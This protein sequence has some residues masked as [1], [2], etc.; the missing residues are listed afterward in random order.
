MV[1]AISECD[2]DNPDEVYEKLGELQSKC[3]IRTAQQALAMVRSGAAKSEREAAKVMAGETG[4]PEEALRTRIKRG[5]KK[6]GSVEPIPE[7]HVKTGGKNKLEKVEKP[8][9]GGERKGA[10]RP[11]KIDESNQPPWERDVGKWG[12]LIDLIESDLEKL[13][14]QFECE[15]TEA[16]QLAHTAV[17][18]LNSIRKD[19]PLWHRAY[20]Y[21]DQWIKDNK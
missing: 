1:R 11:K 2:L 16:L 7:K 20:L 4:E 15:P 17:R 9:H 10:G 12:P 14:K 3:K 8:K 6:L 21:V 13:P 19:D 18:L 5:K